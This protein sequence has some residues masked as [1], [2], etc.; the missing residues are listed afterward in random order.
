MTTF[1]L[2]LN[3]HIVRRPTHLSQNFNLNSPTGPQLNLGT[4]SNLT[5]LSFTFTLLSMN[6]DPLNFNAVIKLLKDSSVTRNLE[7]LTFAFEMTY[8][9]CM[10]ESRVILCSRYNAW[11]ELDHLF[12]SG[13]G[14]PTLRNLKIYLYLTEP[15]LHAADVKLQELLT[16]N[17]PALDRQVTMLCRTYCN[18]DWNVQKRWGGLYTS[19]NG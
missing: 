4:I 14:I 1:I 7:D 5:A 19:L 3:I 8:L 10:W 17:L 13:P 11:A 16:S 6:E 15:P 2:H 9:T 18:S 12:E